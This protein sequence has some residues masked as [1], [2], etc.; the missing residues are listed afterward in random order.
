MWKCSYM[1]F[2]KQH[3]YDVVDDRNSAHEVLVQF[4][5]IPAM[6]YKRSDSEKEKKKSQKSL[7]TGLKPKGKS[8]TDSFLLIPEG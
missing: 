6:F 4:M 1:P 3:I 5:I 7:N 2:Q 8:K